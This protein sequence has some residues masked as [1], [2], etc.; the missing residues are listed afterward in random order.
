MV[1]KKLSE[2][3]QMQVEAERSMAIYKRDDM[4]QQGRH[5]LSLSEQRCILYVISKIKPTD[6]SFTEYEIDLADF[7]RVCGLK[8]ESYTDFK[9]IVK[10]LADRSWW[11]EIDDSESLVRWFNVVRLRK[12][13]GKVIIQLHPDMMPY[14]LELT[15]QGAYYTGYE[16]QY[17]LPMSCQYSPRLYELIKSYE[18][19]K[20]VRW[21][22]GIDEL[23]AKL[24]AE[25]YKN[26]ADFRRFCLDPAVKEINEHTDISLS[27]ETEKEG[28]KIARVEFFFKKKKKGEIAEVKQSNREKLDGDQYTLFDPLGE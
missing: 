7:Y 1:Q 19:N 25:N 2:R 11:A 8:N 20:N 15:A 4:I 18:K 27:Y 5:Q 23:K 17:I 10:G 9:G 26:F 24:N 3:Q 13:S 16:L 28:R 14:L 12:N 22:F 6:S 21:F